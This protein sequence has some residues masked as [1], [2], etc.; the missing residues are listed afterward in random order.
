MVPNHLL[1]LVTLTAMEPPVLSKL[2]Q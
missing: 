1:Q 2:M